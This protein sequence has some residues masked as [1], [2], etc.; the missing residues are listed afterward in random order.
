MHCRYVHV[1]HLRMKWCVDWD[2]LL[3]KNNTTI[4]MHTPSHEPNRFCAGLQW[5]SSSNGICIVCHQHTILDYYHT[6][7][8]SSSRSPPHPGL[9]MYM[10]VLYMYTV[11]PW[12]QAQASISFFGVLTLATIRGRPQIRVQHL[13]FLFQWERQGKTPG[14][15]PF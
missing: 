6:N 3:L 1:Q 10:N 14:K 12:T 5:S 4:H 7:S 2:S 8:P 15:S 11:F 13:L 9:H